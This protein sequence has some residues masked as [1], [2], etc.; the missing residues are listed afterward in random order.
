MRVQA[1]RSNLVHAT[2][3]VYNK[4]QVSAPPASMSVPVGKAM[5]RNTNA[6]FAHASRYSERA[7]VPINDCALD[8]ATPRPAFYCVHSASGVAGTDFLDLA[9]YL[10]P[11]IRFYGIQAPPKQM[12]D[13]AFGSSVESLAEYYAAAL[14]RFQPS[15]A[16]LV[17]G[18]CVGAVIALAMADKLRDLGRDVGPL[19]MIDGVPENTGAAMS[20]WKPRYWFELLRNI[21][22]WINHG[23]LM[24]SR[25][26][27]SLLWSISNNASAIGKS[28]IGLKRGQ[29]LGGGYAI[30]GIMDVSRYQP[31]HKS[32]V[33]RLF[34]ALF[35]HTPKSYPGQV[36]VYEA[37]VKPLLYLPQ[38]GHIWQKFARQ[39]E[40]VEIVGT[41]ISMMH[42]PYVPALAN[43]MRA[44]IAAFFSAKS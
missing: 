35:A 7:I 8:T 21:R 34:E 38:V 23:D 17:G 2:K 3:Y 5:P 11:T 27:H 20:R 39:A 24:R 19:L 15:G 13:L 37:T 31:V 22:G 16:L 44:R 36:V 40:V 28:A 30:D 26:L 6:L 29:K 18:Y 43:D 9:R 32:F 42:D 25:T 10:E 33:N 41:H 12:P 14:N 4:K 1:R